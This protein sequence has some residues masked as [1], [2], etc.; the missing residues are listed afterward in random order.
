MY[1]LAQ[2]AEKTR[3]QMRKSAAGAKQ[4]Y[5]KAVRKCKGQKNFWDFTL[6]ETHY[7]DLHGHLLGASL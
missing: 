5:F 3:G 1:L 7:S 6:S 4:K 2:K